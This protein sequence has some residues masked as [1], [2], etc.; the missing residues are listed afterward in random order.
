MLIKCIVFYKWVHKFIEKNYF[1]AN[2]E[3]DSFIKTRL[4]YLMQNNNPSYN[5]F[6][7]C[8]SVQPQLEHWEQ[9][10]M[11]PKNAY[12][13]VYKYHFQSGISISSR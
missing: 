11:Y 7:R 8:L 1:K 9:G 13:I 4:I 3:I 10:L 5:T 2:I 6:N 12:F